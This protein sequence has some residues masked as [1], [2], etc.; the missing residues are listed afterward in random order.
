MKKCLFALAAL[1]LLMACTPEE[2]GALSVEAN[3]APSVTVEAKNISAISAVLAGKANLG[4]TV[5]SD[6]KVGFQYSK[7]AGILPSNST[8]IEASD[9][10]ASY[11]Y[12]AAITGLDPETKYYFR[13]FVRQNGQDTYGETKEFTTKDVASLLETRDASGVEAT[14]A[15]LNAKLDLADIKYKDLAYGFLWGSS[16][17]AL[18]T[19]Y[20]CAEISDNAISAPLTGL[21]HKTQYWYKAY[22]KL[23][24]QT[25]YGE[26]KTFTTDVLPEKVDMGIKTSDGKTLYWSTRNL[27]KSG[28]VNS[29]EDYGDYYAWGETEPKENYSWSTYKFGTSSSGPFSKY[30]TISSYGS[31][32][33][34]TVLEPEDDVAS[35]KLGGK[36]RMPTDA[37]WTELRTKCTWTWTTNYNGTGVTGRIVTATN[38]NSIFLPAAGY[39][40][41]ASLYSAG[42]FGYSW[43][44]SLNAVSPDNALTVGFESV[45]VSGYNN[46]RCDGHS[47]RPVTE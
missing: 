41:D 32:D 28:F 20:K 37:E 39:R 33:N 27:C 3:L 11:N 43:S 46:H 10:D 19:D 40:D 9:A 36:W 15:T 29:P 44:S 34:K 22:V 47:V 26:V 8:T 35:V 7:S 14:K 16:E 13:S 23:D 12:T 5:A 30:N 18:S 45:G 4:S 17:S 31:I 6:M 24:S 1:S 38:G 25:F 21:S 42:F 2:N